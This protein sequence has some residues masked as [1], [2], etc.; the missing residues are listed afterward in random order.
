MLS[1]KQQEVAYK[2]LIQILE[3]FDFGTDLEARITEW[4]PNKAM[5]GFPNSYNLAIR[6]L[7]YEKS[8]IDLIFNLDDE[9]G[10][11][12]VKIMNMDIDS[13]YQRTGLGR[14]LIELTIALSKAVGVKKICGQALDNEYNSSVGF[15]E[16]CGF[17]IKKQ[18]TITMFCMI[19]SETTTIN[20]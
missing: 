12:K 2:S 17:E 16:K 4:N 10:W 15:Y 18:N 7:N 9:E 20:R 13:K 19:I 5:L 3:D 1:Y 6:Y 11:N 14:R 8:G